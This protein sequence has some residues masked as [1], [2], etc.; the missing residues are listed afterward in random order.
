M[1]IFTILKHE[2][3]QNY[4]YHDQPKCIEGE[5]E[6]TQFPI[7]SLCHRLLVALYPPH[8]EKSFHLKLNSLTSERPPRIALVI[9]LTAYGPIGTIVVRMRSTK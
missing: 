3:A 8:V 4:M 7:V 6:G 2:E 1:P 9:K 5:N